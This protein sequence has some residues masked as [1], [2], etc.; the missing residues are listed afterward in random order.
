LAGDFAAVLLAVLAE[1]EAEDFAEG[2]VEDAAVDLA[3]DFFAV[4]FAAVF[5]AGAAEVSIVSTDSSVLAAE[6]EVAVRVL[7]CP[8]AVTRDS[9]EDARE[10]VPPA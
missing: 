10:P 8:R 5:S 6:V 9:A 2:F 4:D 7:R 1:E 3:V